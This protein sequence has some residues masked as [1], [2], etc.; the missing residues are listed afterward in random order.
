MIVV[1]FFLGKTLFRISSARDLA[2]LFYGTSLSL[3]VLYFLFA[4]KLKTSIHLL[5]MGSALG[6]F[7]VLTYKYDINLVPIMM[8]IILLS[9][10]LGS[11]RLHL[12]AHTPT[13]VYTGFFLGMF[14]QFL[15]LYFL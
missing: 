12:K 5:S 4:V 9:G 2:I 11:A 14:S 13:E 3:S 6:F 8:I 15:V 10:L 1:F 7:I